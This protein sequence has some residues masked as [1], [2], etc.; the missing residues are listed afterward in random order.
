MLD[1]VLILLVAVGSWFLTQAHVRREKAEEALQKAHDEL[2]KRVQDRTVSLS[3]ANEQLKRESEERRRVKES[4]WKVNRALRALS[5]C[6]H[7][8]MRATEEL[9]FMEEVCRIVVEVGGYHMAWVGFAGQDD[10]KTISP[11]AH[12]GFEDGY[13][14]NLDPTWADTQKGRDPMGKAIHTGKPSIVK[15]V[16]TDPDF[17]LWKDEATQR[18]Y[19]SIIALP[20]IHESQTLGALGIYAQKTDAFDVKEVKLL[21]ELADSLAYGIMTL[22]MRVERKRAEEQIQ[23]SKT[24]LQSVFDGISDP[25]ILV[26]RDLSVKMINKAAAEYYQIDFQGVINK[27]CYLGFKGRSDPCDRCIIPSVVIEGRPVTFERKGFID[28]DKLEQVSIYLIREKGSETGSAIIRI[29]DITE[30]NQIQ[31]QLMQSEKLASVGELAAGVAHEINNPINGVINYAQLLM[32]EAEEPDDNG[33]PYRIMKEAERIA[34]IVRNLLSFAREAD[35]K[36]CPAEVRNIIADALGLFKK[37]LSNDGI[38]LNFDIPDDLPAVNVNI[39]K[40]QQVF[41]NLL[42]NARYALNKKY[43]GFHKNKVLELEGK[44]KEVDGKK[45]SCITVRDNGM[46][47]PPNVIHRI[48]DPFFTTKPQGEGTGLGLSISYGIVRDHG[49]HL[50]FES[51]QGEYT[52]VI[53][54]LPIP[55]IS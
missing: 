42:S 9:S 46:G 7:A 19:S 37:Q 50:S 18:G 5:E 40:V 51:K 22:R 43:T 55:D 48:C 45:Y 44:T 16:L 38:Q 24:M 30:A 6:N 39:Q 1:T 14:K 53:V 31:R 4:L 12:M 15:H 34:G 52:K 27:P 36:P 47:I 13:L 28:P 10:A 21:A 17:A 29:S 8:V 2:E 25:L 41:I 32:D 33:I 26:E 49:G 35:D 54:D 11:V 20:L 3:A 23:K